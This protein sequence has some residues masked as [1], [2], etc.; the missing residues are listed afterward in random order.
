MSP[1]PPTPGAPAPPPLGAWRRR[2]QQFGHGGAYD[3]RVNEIECVLAA[4][5]HLV[6]GLAETLGGSG[7]GVGVGAERGAA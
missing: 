3:A 1:P 6:A 2:H 7:R 4:F 5:E